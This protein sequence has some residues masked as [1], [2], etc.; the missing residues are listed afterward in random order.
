MFLRKEIT[1]AV[2]P[3]AVDASA[4]YLS[5]Q[6]CLILETIFNSVDSENCFTSIQQYLLEKCYELTLEHSMSQRYVHIM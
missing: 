2:V 1:D 3:L 5:E 4:E 6:T